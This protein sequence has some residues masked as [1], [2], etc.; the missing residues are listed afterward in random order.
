[1]DF[2][3]QLSRGVAQAWRKLTPSAR[4]NMA[5]ASLITVLAI[6][7]IVAFQARP[8]YRPLYTDVPLE[9]S[10]RIQSLLT[11]QGI[12]FTLQN[13]GQTILVPVEDR[14]RARV[15]LAQE[16]LPSQQGKGFELFDQQNLLANE[17]Q[18]NIQYQRALRVELMRQLNEFDFVKRSSANIT[19][20]RDTVFA[21]SQLP[22]SAAVTLET[23]RDLTPRE[24]KGVLQLISS[25]G[26]GSLTPNNITLMT[27]TGK[28]LSM[29]SEDG[30]IGA[31]NSKLEVI[32]AF[33]KAREQ[34][35]LDKLRKMGKNAV[36]SVSAKFD[37][38]TER[39]TVNEVTEGATVVSQTTTSETKN[40][41]VAQGTPGTAAFPPEGVMQQPQLATSETS[42]EV[43]ENMQPSTT[44][45]E[46]TSEPGNITGYSVSVVVEGGYETAAAA[47]GADPNAPPERTYVPRTA[48]EKTKS[49]S[50]VAAAVG[51]EV[52][53]E[54]VQIFDH[55]F[56]IDK[57][58]EVETAF[59]AAQAEMPRINLQE[60]G[61]NLGKALLVVLGFLVVR[62]LL[63]RAVVDVGP[64]IEERIEMP[65][66]PPEEL[67]KRQVA[68]EVERMSKESPEAIAAILRSWMNEAED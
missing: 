43:I 8:H 1:M 38:T 36:V 56:S 33:E 59:N 57:I 44:T 63:K 24:V 27:T 49:R 25:F 46:T 31:A 45:I 6:V 42:E 17:Y 66:V 3:I 5:A 26:G 28:V 19:I 7:G 11:D 4:V 48:E 35:V 40:E 55:P 47:D 61:I 9:E 68:A 29:P 23:T 64:V 34:R 20:P 16:G 18:Q 13:N 14:T 30:T 54:S 51:P 65:T 53:P 21:E 67:R 15:A 50:S 10:G 41:P 32:E 62:S 37:F 22:A 58:G 39:R 2:F 12:R 60:L 52:S